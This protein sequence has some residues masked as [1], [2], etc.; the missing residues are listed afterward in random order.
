ME[1]TEDKLSEE[2]LM[3]TRDN[4]SLALELS[5][6]KKEI[7]WLKDDL[8]KTSIQ[9]ERERD[10]YM[11]QSEVAPVSTEREKVGGNVLNRLKRTFE[12]F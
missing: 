8:R 1:L 7:M 10:K 4:G 12:P 2:R 11:L 6:A 9:L 3:W 5:E